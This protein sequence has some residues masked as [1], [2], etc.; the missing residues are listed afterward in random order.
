MLIFNICASGAVYEVELQRWHF[1]HRFNI[2]KADPLSSVVNCICIIRS[3]FFFSILS[4]FLI[5]KRVQI[6][7][8]SV[9]TLWNQGISSFL[10]LRPTIWLFTNFGSYTANKRVVQRRKRFRMG[11][12]VWIYLTVCKSRRPTE[13]FSRALL[14]TV[15]FIE[16]VKRRIPTGTFK[17]LVVNNNKNNIHCQMYHVYF[18]LLENYC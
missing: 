5:P 1:S 13:Q 3:K 8:S 9:C 7:S 4:T 2:I 11:M 15:M 14:S 12:V 10:L 6:S 16:Y 17:Y 18:E